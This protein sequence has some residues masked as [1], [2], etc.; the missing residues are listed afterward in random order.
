MSLIASAN[1]ASEITPLKEGTYLAVCNMLVDLG[2]Q[3]NETYK[4]S[5]A[6]ILIGWELPDETYEYNGEIH[7]KTLSKRY[8]NSL[9]DKSNLRQDLISWRSR[10]F[11]QEELAAFDLKNIVGKSCLITVIHRESNGKTYANISS[12]AALP[13]GFA[14]GQLSEPPIVFDL[15]KD[16]LSVIDKLPAW[17]GEIIKKSSTYEERLAEPAKITEVSFDDSEEQLPF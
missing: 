6:K 3:Y 7:H 9:S 8:T 5:S 13:K 16:D 12:I 2:M 1:T 10:D 4:N 11:T 17:I 15:D 14:K